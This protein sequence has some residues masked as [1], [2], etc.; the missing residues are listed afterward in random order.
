MATRRRR[1]FFDERR[2]DPDLVDVLEAAGILQVSEFELFHTAYRWWFGEDT[3]EKEIEAFYLP[4]MFHDQVPLWVR[5][6]SRTVLDAEAEGKLDPSEY[7]IQPRELTQ[8]L[9]DR[10]IRYC[11]WL[12][13]IMFIFMTMIMAYERL[14][15]LSPA[16]I[17][18]PCY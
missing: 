16:C 17:V 5:Q 7:G 18:P 13:V 10:G 12:I 4:Y 9:F 15:P 6:F 1:L 2:F 8:S 3:G 11:L 14:V